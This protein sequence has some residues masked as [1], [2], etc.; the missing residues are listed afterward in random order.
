MG[1]IVYKQQG[2]MSCRYMIRCVWSVYLGG[3]AEQVG[4]LEVH[5]KENR[6]GSLLGCHFLAKAVE[7]L[8]QGTQLWWE[9]WP[10]KK[11]QK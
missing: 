3:S 7:L 11:T 10:G 9:E 1:T 4:F 5:E 2:K 6:A 8:T